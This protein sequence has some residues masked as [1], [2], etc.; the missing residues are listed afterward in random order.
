MVA[1]AVVLLV[2]GFWL[3]L[4]LHAWGSVA[5]LLQ[6][7]AVALVVWVLFAGDGEPAGLF[8][9]VGKGFVVSFVMAGVMWFWTGGV[10][11]VWFLY[12]LVFWVFVIGFGFNVL[13]FSLLAVAISVV[14]Y[15]VFR[16]AL[17]AWLILLSSW[18][19][20]IYVVFMAYDVWWSVFILPYL[21]GPP[22]F[23]GAGPILRDMLLVFLAFVVAC[24]ST[25][26]Y[27]GL[28]KPKQVPT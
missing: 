28:R 1:V 18:Y 24:V 5:V 16:K 3:T 14:A 7:C 6:G 23:G 4:G 15:G 9:F 12:S 19:V 25:A 26:I 21:S 20:S 27:V 10:V 22:Y 11:T 8:E 2:L 17:R 13:P